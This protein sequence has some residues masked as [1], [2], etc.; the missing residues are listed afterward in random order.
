MPC[1]FW[2]FIIINT[3]LFALFTFVQ[4]GNFKL[5]IWVLYNNLKNAMNNIFIRVNRVRIMV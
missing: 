2:M 4:I 1:I 3:Y 5:L